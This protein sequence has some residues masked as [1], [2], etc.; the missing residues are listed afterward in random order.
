[1][2]AKVYFLLLVVTE[3]PGP[4]HPGPWGLPW[5]LPVHLAES[6]EHQQD[7][8][9][10]CCGE[11]CASSC[12]PGTKPRRVG[13][14]CHGEGGREVVGLGVPSED[15]HRP[16]GAASSCSGRTLLRSPDA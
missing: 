12:V 3:G 1:M 9:L 8:L 2:V 14:A 10:S 15:W 13:A 11:A 4:F 5:T 6:T 16:H 7:E